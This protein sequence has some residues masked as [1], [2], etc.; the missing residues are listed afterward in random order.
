MLSASDKSLASCVVIIPSTL[1]ALTM[2]TTLIMTI[3]TAPANSHLYGEMNG[4]SP[5]TIR[6]SD[7][8]F[9]FMCQFLLTELRQCDFL[10]DFTVLQ[11]FPVS[12]GTDD[13]SFI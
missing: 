3:R 10:V 8:S 12:S 2:V 4:F 13:V 7:E 5:N 1:G 6:L 9:L 11:Q